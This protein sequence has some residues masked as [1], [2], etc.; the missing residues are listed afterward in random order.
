M[1]VIVS[2]AA[3]WVFATNYQLM[4]NLVSE[5]NFIFPL[6]IYTKFDPVMHITI[7]LDDVEDE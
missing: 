1:F 5:F 2:D 7:A 3:I 6:T 4:Q